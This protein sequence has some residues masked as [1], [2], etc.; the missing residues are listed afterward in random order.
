MEKVH[1]DN[2]FDYKH[3]VESTPFY[4]LRM[5]ARSVKKRKYE[6]LTEK[7]EIDETHTHSQGCY[8]G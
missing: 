6:A 1:K 7:E 4:K 8:H 5:A 2:S 3:E